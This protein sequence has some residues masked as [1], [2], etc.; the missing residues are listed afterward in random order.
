VPPPRHPLPV[1]LLLAA[2]A[3]AAHA[4]AGAVATEHPAAAAAGAEILQAGGSAVDAAIATAAAVCVVH[5]SSCGIGGG[6]FALVYQ[7][8]GAAHA[9]DFRERA[10]R[11]A[12]RER[13]LEDG[14]PRPE[15]TRRG[16]LAV[17]VPGEVAGWIALHERFG[18]LPR[19]AILAPAIRLARD[20]FR[21]GDA[22]H[23]ARQIERSAD[24]LRADPGL[25]AV[26]LGPNG[27]VPSADF[28]VRNPDLA[29]TLDSI[30]RRGADA[31]YRGAIAEAIAATVQA[32]DGVLV[33]AD[34]AAYRPAWRRP[35]VGSFR[36]RRILAFPPP[37]SGAIVLTILG[38]LAHDDLL[39]LGRHTPAGAH[40]LAA[41]MAHAFADRAQHYGDPDFTGVP[42]A[43]LLAPARL[44]E[45][46][47]AIDRAGDE[48]PRADGT[49]D[50][51]TAHLSVVDAA[52]NAVAL[53]TTINTGFGAGILVP[54]TGIVLNNEMD[55]FV[56]APGAANV[57]G[58]S[59]AG[60]NLIE[61]GKRPQSSMSPTIVVRDGRPELV[62]GASG[63]PL[64]VS[65]TTQVLLDTVT[66]DTALPVAV[67][68]PRL[69]DQGAPQPIL[70]E[71][72]VT[73]GVRE[74]LARGGHR[75]V[76]FPGL[77]AVSA[78]GLGADGALAGGADPRKDGGVCVAAG[79]GTPTA[80][81]SRVVCSRPGSADAASPAE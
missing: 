32:S 25:R 80:G 24:L 21:L 10:P 56:I 62:V 2:L 11:G 46:R 39:A 71:P 53:T 60:P 30:A 16:G 57:Y 29:R 54:G 81:P 75:V 74:R 37:G 44:A 3:G 36:G 13:Y 69:H 15:R 20:G 17:A 59:G 38:I 26:F 22:P 63:G 28:V 33:T 7:A 55:D 66:F 6:G 42:V 41:A 49:M 67:A 19:P 14:T 47:R 76:E 23:L 73:A 35:L 34:L 31:F 40:L 45:L 1:A 78:V 27:G 48:R 68:A 18:S 58:L 52:G 72:G 8:G 5:P 64:I 51:G 4:G 43:T 65:A 9:L 61:P 77:G 50:A 12:V 79:G 70:V